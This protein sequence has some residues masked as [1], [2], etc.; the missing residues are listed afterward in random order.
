MWMVPNQFYLY[1][2]PQANDAACE[3]C[4]NATSALKDHTCVHHIFDKSGKF[5]LYSSSSY[6]GVRPFEGTP[7]C[8]KYGMEK[9]QKISFW[10]PSYWFIKGS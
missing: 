2:L 3:L 8:P 4:R 5:F 7:K 6:T 9:G 1:V 10:S